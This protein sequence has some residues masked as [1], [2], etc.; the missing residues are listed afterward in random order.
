MKSL[1]TLTNLYTTLSQV[2]T[3]VNQ[4][5]G[6]QL[7]TDKHRYSLQKYFDTE[8]SF[9]TSTVGGQSLTLTGAPAIN[10]TSATLTVA[11][12]YPTVQQLVNFSNSNQRT[13]LFTN[14]STSI[15]WTGGLTAAATTAI[16]TVGV[17]RYAIPAVVSKVTNDTITV[18]QL[19][20]VPAPVMTRAEWD[21]INTLPYTSDIPNYFFI[22]NGAVEFWPI[23]STTGNIIQFNYKARVPDFSTAFL[24]SDTSGTAYVAGQA[25]FD[26][27]AGSLSGIAVGSTSITG[28]STSWNT[29]GKFPLNVDVSYYNLYLII[30]APGGDGYAYPISQFNSDTSL[31]LALPIINAPSFT[32]AAH[33]YSIGQY[34]VLFEDFHDMLAYSSLMTYF[35]SIVENEN[36]FKMFSSMVA[37]KEKLMEGMLGSKSINVDLQSTPLA[38]NPNNYYQGTSS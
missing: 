3:D 12:A 21:Q 19:R 2:L 14:G 11:W 30:N 6:I 7:M 36:K 20:Y 9:Q 18:G 1:S 37:D 25:T 16:S 22:Y 31:T 26:Y 4:A 8:R 29:T 38:L 5:M 10:A 34:P 15:T 32:T 35:T 27:Q 23:P 33:G 17:Q 28:A 13:A 24:F